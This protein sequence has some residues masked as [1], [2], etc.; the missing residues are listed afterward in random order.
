M[1]DRIRD[2]LDRAGYN[3]LDATE[4]NLI[5]CFMDYVDAGYFGNLDYEEAKEEI[6]SGDITIEEILSNMKSI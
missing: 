2:I 1:H 4:Q 6:E 5:I 3:H